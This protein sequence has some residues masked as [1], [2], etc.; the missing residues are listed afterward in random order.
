LT[1]RN[2]EEEQCY[3]ERDCV[4]V[5]IR[6]RNLEQS[7]ATKARVQ[8]NK[9]GSYKIS[10]ISKE[11]GK[12]DLSVKVNEDHVSGSPFA[13][14]VRQ[15]K[16]DRPWGVAVNERD[17]IAVTEIGNDTIKVFSIIIWQGKSERSDWFFPGL[18]FAIRTVSV[19]TVI[20]CVFFSFRKP[21]NSTNMAR[22]PYNKLLT[23]LASSSR[24]G[25]YWLLVVFVR[26]SLRSVRPATTSG[27]YSPVR[28]SRLVSKRLVLIE[29]S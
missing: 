8:D 3:D 21:E 12:C 28:P 17:E 24:T 15:F 14:G 2:A 13:V 23:N 1:T 16:V 29:L 4:S 6:N 20:S 19:E 18:D 26:T 10:Y 5:E 11:T 27:Q 25:E 7:C 9:D 22:V